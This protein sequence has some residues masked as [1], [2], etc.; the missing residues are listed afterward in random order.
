MTRWKSSLSPYSI[1]FSGELEKSWKRYLEKRDFTGADKSMLNRFQRQR[2]RRI[3]TSLNPFYA[4]SLRELNILGPQ[5]LKGEKSRGQMFKVSRSFE[6]PL[7]SA[8]RRWPT[9]VLAPQKTERFCGMI[10]H[11]KENHTIVREGGRD[12]ERGINKIR[13]QCINM[14]AE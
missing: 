6:T 8:S 9:C 10:F 5:G 11:W 2:L 4:R 7:C 13:Q 3:R 12:A 1:I 14:N